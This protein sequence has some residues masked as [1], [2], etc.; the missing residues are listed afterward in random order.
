MSDE[1]EG[2][3]ADVL[4]GISDSAPRPKGGRR[5]LFR[6]RRASEAPGEPDVPDVTDAPPVAAAPEVDPPSGG[7]VAA[8]GYL[9]GDGV[10][11][12]AGAH[13]LAPGEPRTAPYGVPR[14]GPPRHELPEPGPPGERADDVAIVRP[15]A[16]TGGRT[17]PVYDLAVETLVSVGA[18]GRDPS[19]IPQ[20]EHRAVAEL[21]REPRSVAEVAALLSLP[22]GVARVLI[23]DMASQGTVVVHQTASTSGDVPD[24]ALMERVLSGLRRL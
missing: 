14:P 1:P 22:L 16:W 2:S 15:Y 9:Y 8:N 7:T 5:G 12:A 17:R 13:A 4:N 6:R 20:Y 11:G 19:R 3:F 24:R 10:D 21:C 18:A 23:G